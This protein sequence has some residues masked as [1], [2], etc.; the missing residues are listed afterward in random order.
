MMFRLATALLLLFGSSA[1]LADDPFVGDSR[2]SAQRTLRVK[3]Q[4][5]KDFLTDL[6][7]QE[8]I[9]FRA[10]ERIAD[11]KVVV[12]AYARP[13]KA[14]LGA[15]ARFFGFEWRKQGNPAEYSLTQSDTAAQNEAKSRGTR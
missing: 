3:G 1:A 5:L 2:L 15:V 11:D 8:M 6:S 9:R 10:D 13:L 7:A 12:I 4:T 14:T